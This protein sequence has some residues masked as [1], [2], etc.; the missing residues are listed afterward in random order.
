MLEERIDDEPGAFSGF[1]FMDRVIQRFW[2][3]RYIDEILSM[4]EDTRDSTGAIGADGD[5]FNA[6]GFYFLCDRKY[7]V[8]AVLRDNG[9]ASLIERV[10][11]TPY[12]VARHEPASDMDGD[13]SVSSTELLAI[14]PLLGTPFT[15]PN[16]NPDLDVDRDGQ[17]N[18]SDYLAVLANFAA[19]VAEGKVST[20]HN[21]IAYSGYVYDEAVDLDLS[22]YRWFDPGMGRWIS[23]DPSGYQDSGSLYAN[24]GQRPLRWTDPQ[25]LGPVKPRNY[26]PAFWDWFEKYKSEEGIR[27]STHPN[28][29]EIQPYYDEWNDLGRP[30]PENRNK[31]KRGGRRGRGGALKKTVGSIGIV[32]CLA[33]N[34]R[35]YKKC[36]SKAGDAY[37]QGKKTCATMSDCS[38]KKS[39]NAGIEKSYDL[40]VAA[41]ATD[42]AARM[43]ACSA[44][45]LRAFF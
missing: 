44:A 3:H 20:V 17:I 23:R 2:S 11:Y 39:C 24:V 40:D 21:I 16:Y 33:A 27:P 7:D 8:I 30:D 13:G 18:T 19:G 15:S 26:P 28:H 42:S 38:T 43:L 22:R 37:G 41:C 4:R 32:S 36:L 29:K 35:K 25:G 12:G 45:F 10:R 9:A 34:S 1:A 31:P 14:L 5:F 6:A